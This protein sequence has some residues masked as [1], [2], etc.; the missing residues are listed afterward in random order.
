MTPKRYTTPESGTI[1][2]AARTSG[3]HAIDVDALSAPAESKTE[4][5]ALSPADEAARM[6][7]G[8][9]ADAI[10]LLESLRGKPAAFVV[11]GL[12]RA[13]ALLIVA[14]TSAAEASR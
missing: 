10:A 5:S 11:R 8:E 14:A 1:L 6:L 12:Q 4:I 7:D 9:L 13:A 3:Q 2:P